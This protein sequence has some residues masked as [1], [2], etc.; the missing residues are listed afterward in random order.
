MFN[1]KRSGKIALTAHCLLNQ[2]S[3]ASG[4][5]EKPCILTEIVGFLASNNIGIIQM[6]C[7]EIVYAGVLR[8]PQIK[9]QYNNATF[10]GLCRKI[11]K[12]I[13]YQ[14]RQYEN[15]GVKVKIVIGVS[16]SPSCSVDNS[17][18]F[19]EALHLALDKSGISVPFY[20]V[21]L[22]TPIIDIAMLKKLIE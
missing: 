17:G 12:E 14:M 18:I 13:A 4:L 8:Q 6:P 19:M 2:N 16:G 7:P 22:K 3:R 20:N 5:A 21:H 1:D 9:E 11:A 15:K 10:N